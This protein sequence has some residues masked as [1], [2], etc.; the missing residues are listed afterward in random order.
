MCYGLGGAEG[1]SWSRR[2]RGWLLLLVAYVLMVRKRKKNIN[3]VAEQGMTC[4]SKER[5]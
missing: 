2:R 1:M 4:A 5:P 3:G